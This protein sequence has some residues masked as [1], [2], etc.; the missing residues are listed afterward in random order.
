M[1]RTVQGAPSNWPTA[2]CAISLFS[3]DK[4]RLINTPKALTPVLRQVIGTTWGAIQKETEQFEFA[5]GG[6][7]TTSGAQ[8]CANYTSCSNCSRKAAG[9]SFYSLELK[10]KGNICSPYGDEKVR[11]RRLMVALFTCM[12]QHGWNVVG[13]TKIIRLTDDNGTFMF[14]NSNTTVRSANNVEIKADGAF[15]SDVKVPPVLNQDVEIF[16]ISFNKSNIIR[17]IDGPSAVYPLVLQ[18]AHLHWPAGIKSE[19]DVQGTK[20]FHLHPT[21]LTNALYADNGD[22]YRWTMVLVEL[23]SLLQDQLEFK[24]YTSAILTIDQDLETW[25]LR[26]TDALWY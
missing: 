8:T 24:L 6:P 9:S 14:R 13:S 26:R 7:C 2:M 18:A 17:I 12:A 25:F 3:V 23:L 21:G 4:I 19:K 10:L 20:E 11:A 22:A 1:T 15:Y 5:K 16:A